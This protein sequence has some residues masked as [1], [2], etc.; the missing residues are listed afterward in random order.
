MVSS[1]KN[2]SGKASW[3]VSL[4]LVLWLPLVQAATTVDSEEARLA[5]ARRYLDVAQ[6]SKIL[7]DTQGEMAKTLPPDQREKFLTLMRRSVHPEVL[8]KAAMDS[9][10][11]IFTAD[12]M[13]ALADFFSSPTGKSAMGKFGLYMADLMP[14]I[15]QEIFRALQSMP[16]EDPHPKAQ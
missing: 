6:M 1:Q 4:V 15:Q 7:E 10:V 8:E 13:N 16:L 5:A 14:V 12:E 11:K 3:L 9:M 2:W